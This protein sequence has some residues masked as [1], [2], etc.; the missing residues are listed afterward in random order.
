[1]FFVDPVAAFGNLRG[2]LKSGGRLAFVCWQPIDG[3][4]WMGIPFEVALRHVPP[5]PPADP[6]A[7][8][9]MAY[10]NPN[11]AR[12]ILTEA[13]FGDID[14]EPLETM[15]PLEADVPRTVQKL[16]MLGPATRLLADASDDIKARVA[17]DLADAIAE[18]Q[19]DSGVM[20]GSATWI[21]SA[22]AP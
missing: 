21:V 6:H 13:G 17:D 20:M 14:I 2:G 1:M 10:A 19:T 11:R 18:F 7:P 22:T 4:P 3:N 8:G 5:P 12:N 9:P 15:L 16:L